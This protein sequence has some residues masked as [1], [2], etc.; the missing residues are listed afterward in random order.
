MVKKPDL[1]GGSL[2]FAL[3]T[4]SE[5]CTKDPPTHFDDRN[6]LSLDGCTILGGFEFF[7]D[8]IHCFVQSSLKLEEPVRT[9]T[10][11]Q[12]QRQC[13]L[14]TQ[15]TSSQLLLLYEDIAQLLLTSKPVWDIEA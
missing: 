4:H 12:K 15:M 7:G 2:D 9:E 10:G 11:R 1:E 14:E 6:W 13:L 3:D 8:N 5:I